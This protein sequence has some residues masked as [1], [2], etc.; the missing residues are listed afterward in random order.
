[1]KDCGLDDGPKAAVSPG[2]KEDDLGDES[3]HVEF[4]KRAATECRRICARANYLAQD[5]PDLHHAINFLCQDMSFR[6]RSVGG[7]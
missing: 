7:R 5:R 3:E 1:M 4:D 6:V 2:L